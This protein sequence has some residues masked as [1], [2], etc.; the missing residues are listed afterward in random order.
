[1]A[2]ELRYGDLVFLSKNPDLAIIIKTNKLRFNC[3]THALALEVTLYMCFF[4]SA[5]TPLRGLDV[6]S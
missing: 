6:S 5:A 4:S 3:S 1:M 2:L